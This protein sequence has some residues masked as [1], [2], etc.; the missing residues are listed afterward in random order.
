M[1]AVKWHHPG[2]RFHGVVHFV[3]KA[4]VQ[5]TTNPLGRDVV[6]LWPQKGKPAE[7]WEGV[8]VDAAEGTCSW[9][10][11]GTITVTIISRLHCSLLRPI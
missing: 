9:A 5:M 1:V 7:R 4:L 3:S 10:S 11:V 8:L 2:S 6:V